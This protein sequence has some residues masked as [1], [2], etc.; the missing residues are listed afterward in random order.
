MWDYSID[1]KHLC[2]IITNPWPSI[3]LGGQLAQE[4]KIW[5]SL[6]GPPPEKS[7]I[8]NPVWH[9]RLEKDHPGLAMR[10]RANPDGIIWQTISQANRR[11]TGCWKSRIVGGEG[12]K[13]LFRP[14]SGLNSSH[15]F[16]F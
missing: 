1:G 4:I 2:L 5:S 13:V 9:T 15:M 12:V 14:S 6:R 11:L 10:K 8:Q 3:G 16:S 7:T